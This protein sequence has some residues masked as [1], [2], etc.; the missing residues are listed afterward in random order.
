MPKTCWQ[1]L[2]DDTYS[3]YQPEKAPPAGVEGAAP[4]AHGSSKPHKVYSWNEARDTE[5]HE[6]EALARD[7]LR[8]ANATMI[9]FAHLLNGSLDHARAMSQ[10]AHRQT[11]FT[12]NDL[13]DT[14]ANQFARISHRIALQRKLN[15]V[16][17]LNISDRNRLMNTRITSDIFGGEWPAIQ[18]QEA[19]LRK[20][21]AE[22]EA[23]KEKKPRA[24]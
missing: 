23:E 11:F 9:A 22:K 14:P 24:Q 10:A 15:V 4:T 18:A 20:G 2:R 1:Q 7:G 12:V 16:R 3:W 5:L 13:V 17:S 8:L 19:E 21:K 6:L